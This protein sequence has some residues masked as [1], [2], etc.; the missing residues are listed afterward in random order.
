LT[1]KNELGGKEMYVL[2]SMRQ[3][4]SIED[5]Q[6]TRRKATSDITGL[7]VGES[8]KYL[9]FVRQRDDAT[10]DEKRVTDLDIKP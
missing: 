6:N 5:R 10:S 3:I 4:K 9:T 8:S 1:K 7:V 2:R